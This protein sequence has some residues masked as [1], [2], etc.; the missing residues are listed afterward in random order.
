MNATMILF[1]AKS[2]FLLSTAMTVSLMETRVHLFKHNGYKH[3]WLLRRHPGI[4]YLC[5]TRHIHQAPC[6]GL[7]QSCSGHIRPGVLML[8]LQ[9]T[10]TFMNGSFTMV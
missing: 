2:I 8:Y 7:L 6:M 9:D 4:L 1:G 5:I 10:I 3:N